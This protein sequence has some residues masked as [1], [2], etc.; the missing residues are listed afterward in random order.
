M[1]NLAPAPAPAGFA[2]KIRQNLAPAGFE[3]SKSS[4]TLNITAGETV[5]CQAAD[6]DHDCEPVHR[7]NRQS[8]NKN[9]N[10]DDRLELSHDDDARS[11]E[12]D[13][14]IYVLGHGQLKKRACIRFLFVLCVN[15]II[16]I[17][18]SCSKKAVI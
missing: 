12:D 3:K 5:T 9:S 15:C 6:A 4:T 18:V 13:G 16:F 1:K 17:H 8:V 11:H 14:W 10:L 7:S 2:I